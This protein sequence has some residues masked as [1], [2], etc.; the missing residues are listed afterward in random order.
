MNWE[1]KVANKFYYNSKNY[2]NY[3][4]SLSMIGMGVGS[5][6]MIISISV[7]NGFEN[8]VHNKLKGFEGD[9]RVI[10]S[11]FSHKINGVKTIM[12]FMQRKAVIEGDGNKSITTIKAINAEK[13]ENFYDF[14]LRGNPPK[15]GEIVIGQD[16]SYRLSKDIGDE[17]TIFSPV[18][19]P[20]GLNIP[21]KKIMKI[22]GVFST[23]ILDYDNRFTFIT[24]EDGKSI[25]RKKKDID[26]Y[27]IRILN[28]FSINQIVNNIK[29]IKGTKLIVQSWEDQNQ[30]LVNAMKM[31]R[32][33]T[34]FI[35]CLI[36][37]VAAF[38]LA[39][40]LTLI[41]MQK[42]REFGMLSVMGATNKSVYKIIIG[43][44]FKKAG[45]GTFIGFIL[46][47]IIILIQRQFS[48][49]PIPAEV[50][51]INALPMEI[52][53]TDLILI[54]FISLIFVFGT[55]VISGKK[56]TQMNLKEAMLWVK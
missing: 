2:S 45:K 26:G 22:S 40:N 37:L 30:A 3:L 18:D 34:I 21:Q 9:V 29:K 44:G 10:S 52:Y 49:I 54:L 23:K 7:L 15:L 38:N 55:S 27:D 46:G 42:I 1:R 19:Q 35:L 20:I 24:L 12:P 56:L 5:F 32:Y 33:G 11:D 47:L 39:S 25:F 36:F 13:M 28:D 6:A 17:I 50:Y 43:L 41:S 8:Q 4:S 31:E 14:L 51:F 16:I 48:I 53:L